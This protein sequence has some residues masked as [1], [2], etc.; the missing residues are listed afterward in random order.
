MRTTTR[1]DGLHG[2]YDESSNDLNERAHRLKEKI[3]YINVQIENG[4]NNQLQD[5]ENKV[6]KL[7]DRFDAIIDQTEK[8]FDVLLNE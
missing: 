4:K 8:R 1:P 7:E 3:N 2:A 6:C 5:Y